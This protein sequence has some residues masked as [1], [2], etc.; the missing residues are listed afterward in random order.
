MPSAQVYSGI[1]FLANALRGVHSLKKYR[2]KRF[3]V[4]RSDIP[5]PLPRPTRRSLRRLYHLPRVTDRA[6]R[7]ELPRGSTTPRNARLPT[8]TLPYLPHATIFIP[9]AASYLLT[10]RNHTRTKQEGVP[11]G[12]QR[13]ELGATERYSRRKPVILVTP[14]QLFSLLKMF[15]ALNIFVQLIEHFCSAD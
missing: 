9:L 1:F 13:E 15:R 14:C 7:E 4:P 5:P 8:T 3:E 11:R 6:L 12:A 10:R 2:T